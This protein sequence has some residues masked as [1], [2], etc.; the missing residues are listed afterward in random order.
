MATRYIDS[1]DFSTASAVWTT[2]AKTTKAPNQWYYFG[3]IARQQVAGLLGPSFTCGSTTDNCAVRCA[4]TSI[5]G[6]F[7]TRTTFANG[8]SWPAGMYRKKITRTSG[9]AAFR[10][11]ISSV[12][13]TVLP[14]GP[15]GVQIQ[16]TPTLNGSVNPNQYPLRGIS[17]QDLSPAF[18]A[19]AGA[20]TGPIQNR[21]YGA[22]DGCYTG[23]N[24]LT[25]Y[26]YN[27]ADNT[28]NSRSNI[29]TASLGTNVL[30][31]AGQST[32]RTVFYMS[33]SGGDDIDLIIWNPC[34]QTPGADLTVDVFCSNTLREFTAYYQ[35]TSAGGGCTDTSYPQ[36]NLFIGNVQNA[37]GQNIGLYDW[38][39]S[40]FM[41]SGVRADGYYWLP[42]G[43]PGLAT[44]SKA[45]VLK[46]II[47]EWQSPCLS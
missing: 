23:S 19:T 3:G 33:P 38:A 32:K 1:P 14:G 25:E 21:I 26:V 42:G 20:V 41:A 39:F 31:L 27:K 6:Y 37:I 22:L 47:V 46:G 7:G 29:V 8:V 10:V 30:I 13:S 11:E 2:A 15:I 9:K 28:F 24:S 45:R 16:Q 44:Q 4:E 35:G 5:G 12:S 36:Q 17:C 18:F 43:Q 40:D 34:T